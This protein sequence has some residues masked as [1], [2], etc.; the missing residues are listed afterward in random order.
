[1]QDLKLRSSRLVTVA[2][3]VAAFLLGSATYGAVELAGATGTNIVYYACLSSTG[4]LS[5]VGTTKPTTT[6]CPAPSKVIFWNS[7]G[8]AGKNG[9]TYNCAIT[10]Y[11]GVDLAGCNLA[12]HN[13]KNASIYGAD[14]VGTN[15]LGAV[16]DGAN[17][18]GANMS[19][20]GLGSASLIGTNLN[21]TNLINADLDRAHLNNAT[22]VGADL[23]AANLGFT[24]LNGANLNSA[25]LTGVIWNF[26]VCP[27]GTNSID[28]SPQTCIG[29]G[30]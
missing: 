7:Q 12:G 16:L 15:L 4:T 14:L 22:M 13:L 10:P 6:I 28:Y 5:H 9:V 30:I 2:A 1:M 20:V 11:V 23:T 24:H 17:L 21:G 18:T 25:N 3:L 26:T 27:D 29:H 8:P 19:A